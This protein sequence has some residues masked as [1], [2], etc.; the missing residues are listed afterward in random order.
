MTTDNRLM[1]HADLVELTGWTRYS[2]QAE[3]FKQTFG[4][5][6]NRRDDGSIAIA[7]ATFLALDAK[8]AGV[9][10]GSTIEDRVEICSPF[11]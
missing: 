2:K 1:T 8:K 5:N 9:A 6:V 11:A 4:L 7:W 10:S 3:W